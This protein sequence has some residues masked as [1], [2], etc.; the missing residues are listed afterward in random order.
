MLRTKNLHNHQKE[1]AVLEEKYPC[2]VLFL[3]CL[4]ISF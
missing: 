3:L 1:R 2:F 4:I